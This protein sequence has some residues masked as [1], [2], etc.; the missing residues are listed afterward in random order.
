MSGITKWFC[1]FVSCVC[2]QA[3]SFLEKNHRVSQHLPIKALD[4]T[5]PDNPQWITHTLPQ[6]VA[7]CGLRV[8]TWLT[9]WPM[10]YMNLSCP[11][12]VNKSVSLQTVTNHIFCTG[13]LPCSLIRGQSMQVLTNGE[14]RHRWV[15]VSLKMIVRN[16]CSVDDLLWV[17][18]TPLGSN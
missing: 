7:G 13:L 15:P 17:Q 5:L 2:A 16:S 3:F 6:L 12:Y 10:W 11:Q 8:S 4:E 9:V 1:Y 14:R 18:Q